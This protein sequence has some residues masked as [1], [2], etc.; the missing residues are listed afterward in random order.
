MCV[1]LIWKS[2]NW[3]I[4]WVPTANESRINLSELKGP[5]TS[6]H[7]VNFDVNVF[8]TT[9]QYRPSPFYHKHHNTMG[10]AVP[11]R[12]RIKLLLNFTSINSR[13]ANPFG[14][15]DLTWDILFCGSLYCPVFCYF[16]TIDFIFHCFVRFFY[17]CPVKLFRTNFVSTH[18]Q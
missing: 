2:S 11:R 4:W 1:P 18:K 10:I 3:D 6:N 15:P 9:K 17:H 7:I 14:T 12:S 8:Y 5:S 13:C 16:I